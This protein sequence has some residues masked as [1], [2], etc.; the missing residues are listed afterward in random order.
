MSAAAP[1]PG[2]PIASLEAARFLP[3]GIDAAEKYGE[4]IEILEPGDMLVLY[5]DGIT[6]ARSATD[7]MFGIPRLD[8]V[9]DTC[10]GS[11]ADY[12]STV[13]TAV[14][15]F[16]SARTPVDDQNTSDRPHRLSILTLRAILH[17]AIVPAV[18]P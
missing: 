11:P 12:I 2:Q 7:E 5:T 17:A 15:A 10:Q 13:L 4:G 6:E 1:A 3:L 8:E 16:E 18:N 14:D 9:L